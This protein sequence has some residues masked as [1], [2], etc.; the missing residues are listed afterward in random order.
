MKTCTIISFESQDGQGKTTHTRKLVD[1][2]ENAGFRVVY[3]KSP[4]RDSVFFNQIYS[5]L[6][7]GWA[8]RHPI[9]F[10]TIQFLNK[11]H[12]QHTKLARL[13]KEMDVIIMDR[14][15]VSMQAY[16][17]AT[18]V[19]RSIIRF[20]SRM[21]LKPDQIFL[22]S[23][24]KKVREQPR[25]IYEKDVELQKSVTSFYHSKEWRSQYKEVTEISVKDE[26][27]ET[28]QLI[29]SELSFT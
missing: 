7:S 10:Q 6:E 11:L 24:N 3:I 19:P 16:G 4:D 9:L 18:G 2:L 17:L 5:T 13:R 28:F 8:I 29:L 12:F 23:G 25:D 26:P 20:M 27:E 14:W 21:L 1:Y 22:L 15:D